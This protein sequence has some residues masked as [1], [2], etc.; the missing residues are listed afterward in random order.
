M[1]HTFRSNSRL[2][3]PS[4]FQAPRTLPEFSTAIGICGWATRCESTNGSTD[5]AQCTS[6]NS[7]SISQVDSLHHLRLPGSNSSLYRS[8]SDGSCLQLTAAPRHSGSIVSAAEGVPRLPTPF[9]YRE[10]DA[11]F[12]ILIIAAIECLVNIP[13]GIISVIQSI[14]F[15]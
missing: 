7:E 6:Q 2:K 14:N 5:H 15:I 11:A 10:V 4:R 12:T 9:N 8:S 1:S 3:G 13:S